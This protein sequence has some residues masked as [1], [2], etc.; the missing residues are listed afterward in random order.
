[1]VTRKTL[2]FLP[3]IFRSDVNRK[4]LGATLDQ[5]VSEPNFI[6]LNG[7]AGRKFSTTYAP[8]TKYITED[9]E[10]R[11]N[12]Q[13]EPAV[14][15]KNNRTFDLYCNY[16][17]LI[18]KI[19]FYG[20][21]TTNHNRLFETEYYTYDPKIDFDKFVNY[22]Q[23]YWVPNGLPAVTVSSGYDV[24]EK[25]YVFNRGLTGYTTNLTG[26]IVNPELT[27]VRGVQYTFEIDQTG[28]NF[29]LQSEPGTSGY[30]QYNINVST[31]QIQGL[32][33]NNGIQTGSLTFTPPLA[34]TQ[35]Y[36]YQLPSDT[37]DYAITRSFSELDGAYW[38]SGANPVTEIDGNTDFPLG[39]YV[40][41]LNDITNS[42]LWVDRVGNIVET[43]L[44]TGVWQI[45]VDSSS[46]IT[47]QHV[48]S[49]PVGHRVKI[50]LGNTNGGYEFF[51][52]TANNIVRSPAI[53]APIDTFYYQDGSESNFFGNIRLVDEIS[54]LINVETDILGQTNYTSPRGIKFTNGLRVTFD[55]SVTP[56]SYQNR[57]YIVEGVGSAIT[58]IA[59]NL[60]RS[61]EDET[62]TSK[63]IPFDIK[64]YDVESF[65]EIEDLQLSIVP[66]YIVMHRSSQDVNAWTRANHWVHQDVITQIEQLTNLDIDTTLLTRAQRPIIEFK[67]N[68][69]LFNNGRI[70]NNF[71]NRYDSYLIGSGPSSGLNLITDAFFQ[72]DNLSVTNAAL[73]QMNFVEGQT[74]IFPND[75]DL[76]VRS[77][78]YKIK[79]KDQSTAVIY[80]TTGSGTLS[81]STSD[82]F[83]TAVGGSAEFTTE[84][85]IGSQ[86]YTFGGSYIGK[87]KQIFNSN[88]LEL[89]DIPTFS[90]AGTAYKIN[91][92]I[93]E[94]E[95]I[96]SV[97]IYDTVVVTSGA[98][99]KSTY[100][101]NGSNW[102]RA[103]QKTT[104]NQ[105]ILFDVINSNDQ[106]FSSNIYVDSNFVGNKV[107]S[108]KLGSSRVDPVLNLQL[109]Y[110]NVGSS[111]ADINFDNNFDNET[112]SYTSTGTTQ[113]LPVDTGFL[114]VNSGRYNYTPVNVWQTATENTKQF[115]H[116]SGRFDGITNYFEID[117]LPDSATVTKNLKVYIN[118]QLIDSDKFELVTVGVR[119][120]IKINQTL[121]QGDS[122][123]ILIYNATNASNLAYYQIP[124]NLEFNPLNQKFSTITL[125]Q[126]RSHYDKILEN[127]VS[128]NN[129]NRDINFS[130]IPGTILQHASTVPAAALFLTD[131]D[132]NFVDS[133]NYARKEYSKF[134][135]KF[136]ELA[137]TLIID[138]NDI[139][140]SVDTIM[141]NLNQ[142]KT[143]STAWYYSDM[144][145]AGE[146]YIVDRYRITNIATKTYNLTNIYLNFGN[147]LLD[148]TEPSNQAILVYLNEQQLIINRDYTFAVNSS[149]LVLSADIN[150]TV[151][152]ILS[153]KGYVSTNGNFIPETPTKLGLHPKYIPEKYLD[154]TY[155]TPIN[156]VQGHDGSIIPAFDDYRDD[157][158]L[159]LE[160]R[161]YNNI[162]TQY[163]QDLID[164]QSIIPGK[165]RT[166]DYTLAEFNRVLTVDFLQWVG[167]NQID[168]SSND[169]YQSND[170]F[171]WNY[172]LTSDSIDGEILPGYWRNIYKYFYDTDRPH[173]HPWEML[174][175]SIKP[176]WW[177]THYGSAPYTSTNTQMWQDLAQGYSRGTNTTKQ[178]CARTNLLDYIPVDVNGNL[179]P[180]TSI[181]VGKF[182]GSKFSQ[183]YVIGDGGPVESAWRRSSEYCFALQRALALLKPAQYFSFFADVNSVLKNTLSDQYLTS[184]N[185]RYTIDSWKINGEL[186]SGQPTI[187]LGYMNWISAYNTSLGLEGAATLRNKLSNIDVNL[188]YKLAGYTDKNYLTAFV[189]QFSPTSTNRSVIIPDENYQ[190]HLNKSVTT[191]RAVYSAVIVEKT[192]T[193]YSV[194]GYDLANPFFTAI[195]SD[196]NGRFYSLQVLT[197]RALI[198]QDF[199]NLLVT[200]PYGYEFKKPQE[201]VDFL[202]GYQR[203]LQFQGFVFEDYQSD[204]AL[205]KDWVLSAR[206][207]LTW[208]LQDWRPGS[209]IVLSPVS[210]KLVILND[211]NVIDEITNQYSGTQLLS[212][213]FKT[214]ALNDI[215]VIRDT[216]TTTVKTFSQQTITFA[217]FNLVQYEHILIFDN[218]TV[219]NDVIYLPELGSRQYRVK[220]TGNKTGDWNGSLYAPG[221][222]YLDG[223]V[224][225][226][227]V[228]R[229]YFKGDIVEYKSQNYVALD[230]IIASD[231]FDFTNWKQSDTEIIDGLIPNFAKNASVS[232]NY[233][234]IDSITLDEKYDTFSNSLIGYRNRSYLEN[235]GFDATAQSKFYQGYIKDK[236]TANA[237]TALYNGIFDNVKNT[238]SLYEEWGTRVG[239]Y[240]DIKN[241]KTIELLLK[242]QTFVGNPTA[243]KFGNNI[244]DTDELLALYKKD[245]Y[246]YPSDFANNIFLNRDI[247][248]TAETDILTAGYVNETDIHAQ[249]YDFVNYRSLNSE[250]LTAITTGYRIWVAKDFN[251]QWQVYKTA[252]TDNQVLGLEY[253]LDNKAKFTFK[254]EHGLQVGQVFAIRNF[255]TDFDGFYQVLNIED[256][257]TVVTTIDL[258]LIELLEESIVGQG[259][260]VKLI[261]QRHS[262]LSSR[263]FKIATVQK[264]INDIAWV[265]NVSNQWQT[266]RLGTDSS[267]NFSGTKH[268]WEID[269]G[270]IHLRAQG[271][272]YHAYLSAN[273]AAPVVQNYNRIWPFRGGSNVT[274][275]TSNL[276]STGVIGFWL[277]GVAM[278]SPDL[279]DFIPEGYQALT[280]LNYNLGY[281]NYSNVS[282]DSATGIVQDNLQYTY[283]GN[284]LTAWQTGSTGAISGAA[285]VNNIPYYGGNLV[286][287]DGHSKIVGFA[288]DGYPIYGPYAYTAPTDPQSG[289]TIMF[290]GYQLKSSS[291]RT[292]TEADDLTTYPMGMFIQD[293]EYTGTGLLDAHNGRYCVTPDYPNGTYAYF[294][295]VDVSGQMTYPYI[296]GNT[297]YGSLPEVVNS[298]IAATGTRPASYQVSGDWQQQRTQQP[299]VNLAS[300]NSLYLYDNKTKTILTYLDHVDPAKGKILGVAQDD[301]DYVTAYD[302]ARYN[303]GTNTSV[304]VDST[305]H[306]AAAQVGKLWWDIDQVRYY[307]YEQ[308]DLSYRLSNWART[309][310][311][312]TIAVY[313]WVASTVLPSEYVSAGLDGVPKHQDDSAYVS[314]IFVDENTGVIRTRYYY[315]VTN[316]SAVSTRNKQHSTISLQQLIENPR[317]Q[318]I[319]YAAILSSRSLALYNV[320]TH[321]NRSN[322]VLSIG[323][324]PKISDN[325]IYSEYDLLQEGNPT[326]LPNPRIENKLID[327]LIGYDIQNNSVPDL[328]LP[329]G[330]RYGLDTVPEQTV[331]VN[332]LRTLENILTYV[333]GVLIQHPVASRV[334]D[335]FAV[336]SDNLYAKDP[337]ST[338]YDDVVADLEEFSYVAP[339]AAG[340][341]IAGTQYVIST[342]G[343]TNFTL[344]GAVTNTV[345]T[346]FTANTA[347]LGTGTVYPSRILVP[348]NENYNNFWTVIS[349]NYDGSLGN[350]LA[351]QKFDTTKFWRFVDWYAT[352][353]S[354]RTKVNHAV[355]QY[356]DT[357]KLDL[358]EG[359]VVRV[360]NQQSNF[361]LYVYK[362]N[363][364]ELIGLGQGTIQFNSNC[365]QQHGYDIPAYDT[366]LFDFDNALELR[367]I[368]RA[369]KEDL[370]VNDLAKYYNSFIFNII[371]YVLTE[372][373]YVDWVFKSSF[374]TIVHSIETLNQEKKYIH[375]RQE[376]YQKYVEEVKPYRTKLREYILNYI[377][378]ENLSSLVVTDFDLPAYYH[379]ELDIFRSPNGQLGLADNVLLSTLPEYNDWYNNYKYEVG[380]LAIASAGIGHRTAPVVNVIATDTTGNSAQAV[381]EINS[382]GAVTATE[383]TNSGSGYT[384]TPIVV[385]TGTGSTEYSNVK[386]TV[387]NARLSNS[388]IRKLKTTM[389]FDRVKYDTV[390]V[391]WQANTA[392][393]ANTYVSYSG[394]GYRTTANITTGT[395]FDRSQFVAITSDI[396]DNAN[397]RIMAFYA[398]T[399][400]MVPKVLDRLIAGIIAP[401]TD[402][403][404][405]YDIDT[406][407]AGG[408]F[409][410]TSIPVTQ[411]VAGT[412]YIITSNQETDFTL[413]G[414]ADNRIGLVFTAT[415]PGT[416]PGTAALAI[417]ESAF[418]NVSGLAAEDINLVGG[419]FV[420]ELFSRAPEE[421]LPGITYD[422]VSIKVISDA[423]SGAIG[424][425]RFV[426]ILGGN[427]TTSINTN[428]ITTLA[429]PLL[430]SDTTIELTN[431]SAFP[432]PSPLSLQPGVLHING[433]RIEYYN[434]N[435]NT[436]GQLRRG[437]GGTAIATVHVTGSTVESASDVITI[438][439]Q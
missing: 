311:G 271:T 415:G 272:P 78:I 377:S 295:T 314:E 77:Q 188:S 273:V 254:Y 162:K 436:L 57:T 157:L 246:S 130:G 156:V 14:V 327:S 23:Y 169:S 309:F 38:Q 435:G 281:A 20:G 258:T 82:K 381:T 363:K 137:G 167:S 388:K 365:W 113:Q 321:I 140:G 164:I 166:T 58:L 213:G 279:G 359:N 72:I 398:P 155:R 267:N 349:K 122:V 304:S 120:A 158:L 257:N 342:T 96:S 291:Y 250:I 242:E 3:S 118:N 185:Q 322:T 399:A 333:N 372:Q 41:F 240:G 345:G 427:I 187:S 104:K 15:V 207:F 243:F 212:P 54:G 189:D 132:V 366:E 131:R 178:T 237:I 248:E 294:I 352:G 33:G 225:T 394:S 236:G 168:F 325:N 387:L 231:Q 17:D 300:V 269:T 260:F 395:V 230:N 317:L 373:K 266:Y 233:Y 375:D 30:K 68:L 283:I 191:R 396:F 76:A 83:V 106:S 53:T 351:L 99:A 252:I 126:V 358:V 139:P 10:Q 27:L 293:Y 364:L 418:G 341:L 75:A 60:I 32:T 282:I 121:T 286:H 73:S 114:R 335:K 437:V 201:V 51:K 194:S 308:D 165:F 360:S 224:D 47:L 215:S 348:Q 174:G 239:E 117:I 112:F 159:E 380:N 361:E 171:T 192:T 134:K 386:P 98:S 183:S 199:T 222:V 434:K 346:V 138:T 390:V 22:S 4:F 90:S 154:T 362:N 28:N 109:S 101:F 328:T 316:K 275:T 276:R 146:E 429:Q 329:L 119:S 105:P 347:G 297:F 419:A 370:F 303:V 356:V 91:F 62:A 153:V 202:M 85:I 223:T 367:Y 414:A 280:D 391:D 400:N 161:I 259:E 71:I 94:L 177:V 200:V 219:F 34:D 45:S 262:T 289:I 403:N 426:D 227:Q 2:N 129:P 218:K 170:P 256:H 163:R 5:L 249:L 209:L 56:V 287:A 124:N 251:N 413:I 216:D 220:L 299:L 48:R 385:V 238:V 97:Q 37:V 74:T 160:R 181:M 423:V 278:I 245:L 24:G 384:T 320:D 339:I 52:D 26:N 315:W 127:V 284:P 323:Y 133:I 143:S 206:E 196:F 330:S 84:I 431:A 203:Y 221:F 288:A 397:D 59:A 410:G 43:S 353:Y 186:I 235:L 151:G 305:Y 149:A 79:F 424:Y 406:I 302:P 176:T 420:D 331:L 417:N 368:F 301:L 263:D 307:N 1:M 65:D 88:R 87:V 148:I 36:Y 142:V 274:A 208:T 61:I 405:S 116:F 234:D 55:T 144:C 407:I 355:Q 412:E 211:G 247:N 35:D 145:A 340:N 195:P 110:N 432:V 44:R 374:V 433:E 92:P 111:L 421:L 371:K 226:W 205:V 9:T 228:G 31:R 39:R 438:L 354:N 16:T 69:Q 241:N 253:A 184:S 175:Y 103:Q 86:L 369:I 40:V 334:I 357:Y 285:E 290:S 182:N 416:G 8:D 190:I 350:V 141:T 265:D 50:T 152:D 80:D 383:I 67:P 268:F 337:E 408:A 172:N 332:R 232:Q 310:P 198:F 376:N 318:N 392:Y 49:I 93:I 324:K 125:G 270:F 402:S 217:D 319:P 6:S 25:T 70:F 313:E 13:F 428:T 277:N 338:V 326:S 173:T 89:T 11:Q 422:T 147:K 404:V 261:P 150:L 430:L 197:A 19:N 389:R 123:D 336:Y 29:Y 193:G 95:S 306:W 292:N 229:D 63:I 136:L 343:S 46:R 128:S 214:I 18:N 344:Y 439:T 66:D 204:L 210:D 401:S 7:F 393:A 12:Y 107:F 115:Q 382:N 42:T 102:I 298:R 179:K 64:N 180:P 378:K 81:F 264:Q 411:L 425:R 135:N 296:V 100:W 379:S 108:Y 244:D 312:S 21:I 255:N 409:S